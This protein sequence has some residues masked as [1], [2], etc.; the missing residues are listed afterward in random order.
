[1]LQLVDLHGDVVGTVPIHDGAALPSWQE[2]SYVSYDE[3]GHPQPLSGGATS[4]APPR[5]GWLGA[6][7][8]SSDTRWL[9]LD[10][11]TV[12]ERRI[13]LPLRCRD[14]ARAVS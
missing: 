6:A 5:Y 2:L 14:R 1:M 12:E 10:A 3:F 13:E 9:E 7:Q 8:R 4:N 11:A